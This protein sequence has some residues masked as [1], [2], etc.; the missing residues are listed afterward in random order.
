[1][2]DNARLLLLDTQAGSSAREGIAADAMTIFD[3]TGIALPD[4]TVARMLYQRALANG[5]GT[6]IAWPW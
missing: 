3:M 5:T 1:M 2:P 6:S 4:L